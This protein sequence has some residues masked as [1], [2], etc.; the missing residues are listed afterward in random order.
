MHGGAQQVLRTK[1][2]WTVFELLSCGR[3]ESKQGLMSLL[4]GLKLEPINEPL[5]VVALAKFQ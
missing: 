3:L 1:I 5:A 4:R 2:S